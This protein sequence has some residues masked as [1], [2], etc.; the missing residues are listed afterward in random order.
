MFAETP[1][2]ITIVLGIIAMLCSCGFMWW[3]WDTKTRMSNAGL[4]T[5]FIWVVLIWC[6]LLILSNGIKIVRI[7]E[8]G[9]DDSD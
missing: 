2:W 1:I 3:G 7:A 8:T 4:N 9:E 6:C 5:S